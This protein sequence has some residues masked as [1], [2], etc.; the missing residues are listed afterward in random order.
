MVTKEQIYHSVSIPVS[1]FN[2][3]PEAKKIV[4]PKLGKLLHG[5]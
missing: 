4:F 2:L 5:P 1:L 3:S